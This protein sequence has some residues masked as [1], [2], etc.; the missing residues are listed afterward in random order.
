MLI[1]TAL[2]DA[3]LFGKTNFVMALTRSA[4][5]PGSSDARR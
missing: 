5:A 2:T 3:A 1:G 4:F